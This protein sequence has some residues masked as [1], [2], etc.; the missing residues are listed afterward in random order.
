MK[1]RD[2]MTAKPASCSP[3][4]SLSRAAQLMEK[5]DCGCIPVVDSERV[6]GVITDRDI[7]VRGVAHGRSSD[8]QVS[9]LMTSTTLSC[10][11]DSDVNEVERIMADEQVRRVLV[12][13]DDGHCVGIVAQADVARAADR[14]DGVQDAE[15]GRIVERISE[16]TRSLD[17]RL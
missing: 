2:I 10:S 4:D 9:E 17:V 1:V 11:A 12:L 6:V 3:Q 16:P 8:T 15:V 13:D 5:N 7:A 14:G